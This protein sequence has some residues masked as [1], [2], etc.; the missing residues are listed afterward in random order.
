MPATLEL[1]KEIRAVSGF[2]SDLYPRAMRLEP[3]LGERKGRAYVE[4]YVVWQQLAV[5]SGLLDRIGD[6]VAPI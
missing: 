1:V 5:N 2:D 3:H 4:T 6:V